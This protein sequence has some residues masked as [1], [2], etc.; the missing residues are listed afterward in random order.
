MSPEDVKAL[1]QELGCTARE[2]AAA[3]GVEHTDVIAWERGELFPTKRSCDAMDALRRKGPSAV[4][5]RPRKKAL[6]ATPMA[7]LSDPDLWRL[8]RKLLAHPEL[9]AAAKELAE[10][11]TDPAD[12]G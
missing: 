9:R 8:V 11:Y 10:R 2:L 6:A 4:P 7:A 1:R 3:L 5:R 12:E